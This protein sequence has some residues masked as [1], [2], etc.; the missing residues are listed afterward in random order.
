MVL[1]QN[2]PNND[3]SLNRTTHDDSVNETMF[4]LG[5]WLFSGSVHYYYSVTGFVYGSV[6][7][8]E[9]R[10]VS[11]QSPKIRDIMISM[12][13]TKLYNSLILQILLQ[14]QHWF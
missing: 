6:P 4:F 14:F 5:I 2:I 11:V 1:I 13:L 7:S 10:D 9:I 8:P 3:D 12:E